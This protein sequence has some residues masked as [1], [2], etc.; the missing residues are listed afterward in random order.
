MVEVR[1]KRVWERER[2]RERREK[3][4][5]DVHIW[6][7][8]MALSLGGQLHTRPL[9]I[10]GKKETGWEVTASR[11]GQWESCR[12]VNCI[13]QHMYSVSRLHFTAITSKR[14]NMCLLISK[15]D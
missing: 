1:E 14:G 9:W 3:D 11:K 4:R 13:I 12:D 6:S 5:E 15:T 10:Y 2:E 7:C 8:S